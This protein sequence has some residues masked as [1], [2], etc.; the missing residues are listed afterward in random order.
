MKK[1]SNASLPITKN[2]LY[3]FTARHFALKMEQNEISEKS[4]TQVQHCAMS[5][6]RRLKFQQRIMKS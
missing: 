2:M 3:R 6:E 1:L 4:A 5:Q